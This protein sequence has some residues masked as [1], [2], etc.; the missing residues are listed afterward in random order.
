MRPTNLH[1][2]AQKGLGIEE[3]SQPV[4]GDLCQPQCHDLVQEHPPQR[5][6]LSPF[7]ERPAGRSSRGSNSVQPQFWNSECEEGEGEL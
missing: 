6:V 1:D 3:R 4:G 2:D 5:Q 7:L